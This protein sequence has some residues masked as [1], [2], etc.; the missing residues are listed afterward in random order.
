MLTCANVPG[1]S[2]SA[3]SAVNTSTTGIPAAFAFAICGF[4]TTGD[5]ATEIT[6][7]TFWLI[8]SARIRFHSVTLPLPS[9]SRVFQPAA[10]APACAPWA[11]SATNG[12]ASVEV[13]IQ[14]FLPFSFD[15]GTAAPGGLNCGI[16][17]AAS[18]FALAWST[19]E[20]P[21]PLRAAIGEAATAAARPAATTIPIPREPANFRICNPPCLRDTPGGP[22]R[23]TTDPTDHWLSG[24]LLSFRRLLRDEA[25]E[26]DR[27]HERGAVEDLLDPRR[28]SGQLEAGDAGDEQVERDERPERVEA[29]GLDRGRAEEGGGVGRQQV[30]RPDRRVGRSELAGCEDPARR[31]DHGGEDEGEPAQPPDRQ[32]GQTRDLPPL[33]DEEEVAARR[34]VLVDVPEHDREPEG[35]V[36]RPHQAEG[37]V[38]REAGDRIGH[39]GQDLAARDG[40]SEPGQD[41]AGA[42]RRDERVDAEADDEEPVHEPDE[43]ADGEHGEQRGGERPVPAPVEVGEQRRAEAE[44]RGDG[45]VELADRERQRQCQRQQ[46]Q[47]RLRVDDRLEVAG[48]EERLRQERAEDDDHGDEDEHDRVAVEHR[49]RAVR[50]RPP[51]RRRR[52]RRGPGR[53][54]PLHRAPPSRPVPP[55]PPRARGRAPAGSPRR[56]RRPPARR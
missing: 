42:Q 15:I 39:A 46:Q 32:P 21:W 13:M 28:G 19:P 44:H 45:E 37:E 7:S 11:M 50:L 4:I 49:A 34:R 16:F 24:S 1:T 10:L 35:H 6:A 48:R 31:G 30:V 33:A 22:E 43:A 25:G 17:I 54:S 41:G 8:A 26:G 56:R 23:R 9:I 55:V 5:D 52:R 14:T 51:R 29:A 2:G 38:R 12:T 53:L 3:W 40:E 47:H 18:T 27:D 20:R 36:R